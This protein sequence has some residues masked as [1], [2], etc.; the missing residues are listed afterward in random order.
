MNLDSIKTRV[1]TYLASD[2]RWPI[3]VDFSNRENINNFVDYF[4]TESNTIF[5]AD[6]F[7]GKDGTFKLE[8]FLNAIEENEDNVFVVNITAFLKLQG[9][10]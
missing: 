3:I 5:P 8:E 6:K 4:K 2:K 10:Q 1:G 9:E 7:C